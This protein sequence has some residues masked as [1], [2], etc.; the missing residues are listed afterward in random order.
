MR[1]I[2][3]PI[4]CLPVFLS[5]QPAYVGILEPPIVNGFDIFSK[6][7][8]RVAFQLDGRNSSAI[9][10]VPQSIRWTILLRGA[11]LGSVTSRLSSE[12]ALTG[13]DWVSSNTALHDVPADVKLPRIAS[14]SFSTWNGYYESRPLLATTTSGVSDPD[15]W[16]AFLPSELALTKAREAFRLA[17]GPDPLCAGPERYPD[18]WILRRGPA[19]K[20]RTGIWIVTL[21]LDPK[22]F[23]CD[24][25]PEEVEGGICL[26]V[27]G[28]KAV[29]IGKDL[30][31]LDAADLDLDGT[32]ELIFTYSE[33][34]RDGYVLLHMPDLAQTR[35]IWSYH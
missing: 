19:Y 1:R 24:E 31:F 35:F 34:N 4:V 30:L 15:R 21:A 25:P 33:Y 6:A 12:V 14:K 18:S 5:A 20:S 7:H 3:I 17:A 10:D 8:I 11:K 16:T 32:S 28:E 26:L 27:R 2:L 9:K 13:A 22:R 29:L 23:K